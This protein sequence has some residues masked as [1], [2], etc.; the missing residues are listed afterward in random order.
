MDK[1]FFRQIDKVDELISDRPQPLGDE[2]LIC[3]CFCVNA[4]DIRKTCSELARV[5]LDTLRTEFG[6]GTGCQGCLKR[7]D[8][9]LDRIFE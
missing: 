9:W 2:A 6:L 5:D 8:F 1:E 4:G 7:K 3:E